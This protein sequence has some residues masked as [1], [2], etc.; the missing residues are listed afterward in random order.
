MTEQQERYDAG[1]PRDRLAEIEASMAAA[2]ELEPADLLW[3]VAEVKRLRK[4]LAE[5]AR[6]WVPR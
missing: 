5:L 1:Q 3:L 2:G 6:A 4:E